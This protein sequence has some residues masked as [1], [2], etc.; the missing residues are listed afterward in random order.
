MQ[1]TKKQIS[2]QKNSFRAA[3]ETKKVNFKEDDPSKQ[4]HLPTYDAAMLK[5]QIGRNVHAYVDDI[6]VMTRKGS[7]LISDLT[8]P[9][10]T[11][12]ATN[13]VISLVIVVERKEEGHEY[14]V[15]RPVYYISE[16][17]TESKQR[18]PHFQK[19][20]YG[21]FLGSRKL[22][23]YFQE[24]P[25]TVV[26]KAPLS[27]ILNN[28]DATGRTAKWGIELS[29][30]DIAYKPRIAV[31]SQVL[32]DFVA[33]WTEAPDASLEPETWVMHLM[34]PSSIKAQEPESP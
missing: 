17:L 34:D 28:A 15:Q 29:A 3:I 10:T 30:F 20:A 21:V 33:D 1:T 22:R 31:K 25:V 19:L 9:S 8:K 16:V 5:D 23:H 27:T 26:S 13:K 2:E 14:D 11:S 7:D 24:H 32:A 6:A 18:Y 4:C 12:A